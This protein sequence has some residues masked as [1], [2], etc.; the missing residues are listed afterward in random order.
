MEY[1]YRPPGS[2]MHWILDAREHGMHACAPCN[3]LLK[4]SQCVNGLL[5]CFVAG[6][7]CSQ[8]V[9]LLLYDLPEIV[10]IRFPRFHHQILRRG[11]RYNKY[12]HAPFRRSSIEDSCCSAVGLR[13]CVLLSRSCPHCPPTYDG[14]FGTAPAFRSF[15]VIDYCCTCAI[16]LFRDG[17]GA[18]ASG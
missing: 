17:V 16:R 12:T 1:R 6:M 9:R 7:L 18:E 2:W 5:S 10:P 3:V 4:S 14:N 13:F 11:M 8:R 15:T